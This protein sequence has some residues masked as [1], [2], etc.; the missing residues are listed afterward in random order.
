MNAAPAQRSAWTSEGRGGEL[1][2]F[3]HPRQALPIRT[4]R[5]YDCYA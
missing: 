4:R 5:V 1:V 3:Y 2:K